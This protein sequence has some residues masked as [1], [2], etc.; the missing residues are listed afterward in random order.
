MKAK[1]RMPTRK[2][3]IKMGT[4]ITGKM[5]YRRKNMEEIEEEELWKTEIDADIWLLD[6][7]L[8]VEKPK[9]E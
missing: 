3:K 4:T 8:T 7:Q 9:K 6:N 5:A 2:T 1:R